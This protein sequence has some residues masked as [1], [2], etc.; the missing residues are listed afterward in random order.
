MY[1]N[2]RLKIMHPLYTAKFLS[3]DKHI[4]R[5]IFYLLKEQT[6][7]YNM[8]SPFLLDEIFVEEMIM[9]TACK[10]PFKCLNFYKNWAG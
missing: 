7:Q 6:D 10:R 4:S 9:I 3:T 1:V 5:F 8:L 2:S